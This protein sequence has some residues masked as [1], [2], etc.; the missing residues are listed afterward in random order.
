MKNYVK[1]KVVRDTRTGPCDLN[2]CAQA[3]Y[4]P[5]LLLVKVPPQ[6]ADFGQ[7]FC[8]RE[9]KGGVEEGGG[10]NTEYSFAVFWDT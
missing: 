3:A 7:V 8:A 5:H 10:T 6:S 4:D 9:H 1:A 2:F